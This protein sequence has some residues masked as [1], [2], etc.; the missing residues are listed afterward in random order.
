MSLKW[1]WRYPDPHVRIVALI[2]DQ[3]G[4]YLTLN[5]RTVLCYWVKVQASCTFFS[6]VWTIV[7]ICVECCCKNG[8]AQSPTL[9]FQG[10][11]LDE[12]EGF[13][14]LGSCISSVVRILDKPSSSIQKAQL[15]FANFRYLWHRHD[16]RLSIKS[17]VYTRAAGWHCPSRGSIGWIFIP[18]QLLEM[19]HGIVVFLT[20][21][22]PS[23][24]WNK[25]RC[26]FLHR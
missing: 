18:H 16:I 17:R 1:L 15:G 5:A 24:Q 8:L 20:W 12:A 21:K 22:A 14:H 11:Q 23:I 7:Y 26:C 9:F 3:T 2:V 6:T 10:E 4:V 13:S 19:R 25:Q